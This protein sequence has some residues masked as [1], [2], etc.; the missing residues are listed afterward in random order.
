MCGSALGK[1][2]LVY[3]RFADSSTKGVPAWM[4]DPVVCSGIRSADTPTV[5]CDA[6]LCLAQLLE[7]ANSDRATLSHEP[8]ICEEDGDGTAG[9]A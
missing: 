6:L 1:R 3:V 7:V 5:D 2:D 4:F 8:T 9:K